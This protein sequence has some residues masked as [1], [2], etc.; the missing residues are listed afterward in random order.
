M[1]PWVTKTFIK[2]RFT[3]DMS[4]SFRNKVS[5]A[6]KRGYEI[7][8]PHTW[9]QI[10]YPMYYL[11]RVAK[12]D[13]QADKTTLRTETGLTIAVGCLLF[14]VL[15]IHVRFL[16]RDPMKRQREDSNAIDE[17]LEN[18]PLADSTSENRVG[19]GTQIPERHLD[20]ALDIGLSH[21]EVRSRQKLY[22][23]NEIRTSKNWAWLIRRT[24]INDTAIC[25]QVKLFR[26]RW[27]DPILTAL[28]GCHCSVTQLTRLAGC[29]RRAR[30]AGI[31]GT[32]DG[33]SKAGR[34]GCSCHALRQG[35]HSDGSPRR[36][37]D[38]N[39]GDRT[40]TWGRC[41]PLER[42]HLPQR[43]LELLMT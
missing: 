37:R 6:L 23:P 31:P 16:L 15:F 41:P 35:S 2:S 10:Y 1:Q 20:T 30:H 14:W 11:I 18:E 5:H 39:S 32:H 7:Y 26:S 8:S 22:G 29:C 27:R 38:E 9:L 34:M 13:R 19:L 36:H 28:L 25:S 12:R 4:A 21:H 33:H 3:P 40:R 42:K 24:L 17:N 43:S